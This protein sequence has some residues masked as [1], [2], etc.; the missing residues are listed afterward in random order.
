MKY[1]IEYWLIDGNFAGNYQMWKYKRINQIKND[2]T[3]PD[4][5]GMRV[6][7]V[8]FNFK[9]KVVYKATYSYLGPAITFGAK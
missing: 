7:K 4:L 5:K 2:W 3:I 8:N 1:K 6:Y 9:N